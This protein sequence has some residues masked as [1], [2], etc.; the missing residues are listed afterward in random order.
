MGSTRELSVQS[1]DRLGAGATCDGRLCALNPPELYSPSPTAHP[2][3]RE[4]VT[5]LG[6][7]G[8]AGGA[9]LESEPGGPCHQCLSLMPV[10]VWTPATSA[11]LG[12][13]HP[14]AWDFISSSVT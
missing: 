6:S 8:T 7:V 4:E 5:P 10:P 3:L 11:K 13:Q 14:L 9:W 12:A 2:A 1:L